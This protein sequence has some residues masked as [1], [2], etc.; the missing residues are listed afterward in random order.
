MGFSCQMQGRRYR[1]QVQSKTCRT[2]FHSS[3][4][5][6]HILSRSP[7]SSNARFK[8]EDKTLRH[9]D[10]TRSAILRNDSPRTPTDAEK[11]KKTQYR[12]AMYTSDIYGATSQEL[13]ILGHT[14]YQGD[15]HSNPIPVS[16]VARCLRPTHP[17]SWGS[18]PHSPSIPPLASRPELAQ[19]VCNPPGPTPPPSFRKLPPRHREPDAFEPLD[20]WS[21]PNHIEEEQA[22]HAQHNLASCNSLPLPGRDSHHT[23]KRGLTPSSWHH[24]A[25]GILEALIRGTLCS[26]RFSTLTT[27]AESPC[28]DSVLISR[29]SPNPIPLLITLSRNLWTH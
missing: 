24:L 18:G 20:T 19:H 10:A 8:L 9:C 5:F 26:P 1:G 15:H 12:E 7:S 22:L 4:L 3:R 2:R 17:P 28:P 29:A 21:L 16:W 11:M 27:S 25:Q 13:A 14:D 23:T 6:R